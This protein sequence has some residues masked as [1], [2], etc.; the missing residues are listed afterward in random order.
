MFAVVKIGSAQ[1]KV[2]VGDE[3]DVPLMEGEAGASVTFPEVLLVSENNE[4][5]IG[6]PRV[7][8]AKVKATV[9]SH[10]KGEKV[11]VRRFKSKVR[12]R[13]HVGFRPQLTKL[14]ITDIH[15]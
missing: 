2:V 6:T 15:A 10:F 11:D 12:E 14:R 8:G 1:Y 9:V 4:T 13:R 7:V 5:K 3:I